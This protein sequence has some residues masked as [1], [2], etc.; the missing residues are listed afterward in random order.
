MFQSADTLYPLPDGLRR[1]DIFCNVIDNFGDIG[2][3]WRLARQL[4]TEYGAQVR[5]WVDD[6]A[7][8]HLICPQLD[9]QLAAQSI[10]IHDS[11][12]A[13]RIEVCHWLPEFPAACTPGDV[14]IEAFA[15][16]LPASFEE[17]MA[18]RSLV[19][20]WINLDYL[21]A[22]EW[23]AGCHALPSPHP[24]L[25]LTKY[26][27]FPGFDSRS[28]GLLRERNLD[29]S[30]RQFRAT[31]DEQQA[32]WHRLGFPTPCADKL[33]VSFFAYENQALPALLEAWSNNDRP[34]CLLLP[35]TR[36]QAG[37]EK[38]LGASLPTGS[39]QQ[40]GALEI[41]AIPFLSQ[42]EYDQLLW[43]CDLNFVR[44]E[45]S[46]V[47]AQWAGV[48]LVWH[49]YPQDEEAHKTKLEAFLSHYRTGL[50]EQAAQA[51][52]DLH[53][54]WN[55]FSEP[56]AIGVHWRSWQKNLPQLKEAADSW[57]KKLQKQEDLCAALVRFCRSKL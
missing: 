41:R 38:W 16:R 53:A 49:I 52:H 13:T 30:R 40:R 25:K 27:F 45:D 39:G 14:V 48:P 42:P 2:V 47:R 33:L 5:L 26:F 56:E 12:D 34:V 29:C 44:G 22:E 4:A 28:G 51:V 57:Q 31:E 18:G 21:S 1:W 3:C 35:P 46:F 36:P 10:A 43:L 20:V 11:P 50:S 6:L 37:V 9:P 7:A 15:C 32:F 23:V 24:R 55:G 8:F 17:K 54:A 19:P